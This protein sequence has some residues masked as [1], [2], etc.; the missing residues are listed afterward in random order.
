M[1]PKGRFGLNEAETEMASARDVDGKAGALRRRLAAA[2]FM[3]SFTAS[4]L[5]ALPAF[6]PSAFAEAPSQPAD[7]PADG[8]EVGSLVLTPCVGQR[9]RRLLRN[10]AP[11][12]RPLRR[13]A[14]TIKIGFEFYPADVDDP[15]GTI[16][17]QEG[18]PGFSTTGTRT[19][20]LHLFG[21]LRDRHN[22][23][24]VDKR[25]TGLSQPIDCPDLQKD[26]DLSPEAVGACGAALGDH[27][28]DYGTA[29]AAD[30]VAAVIEALKVGPVAY[31]GD[32]YGTYFGAVFAARHPTL[33]STLVLDSAY[34]PFGPDPWYA[35]EDG[36]RGATASISS[37]PARRAAPPSAAARPSGSPISSQPCA[38]PRFRA[39][40]PMATARCTT[41]RSTRRASSW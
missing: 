17:A 36:R 20:F 9:R 23:L 40:R 31:Y 2:F 21:T 29:L 4:A 28:W 24:L 19:G 6:A 13:A 30:D 22:I 10:P 18:G 8:L 14:G 3:A 25:G 34:P 11:P 32:S 5:A 16:V 12:A 41:S 38:R 37:A 15:V 1:G 27:A 35:S 26:P 7:D 33:L 39:A